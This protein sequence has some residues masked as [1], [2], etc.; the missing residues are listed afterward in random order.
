MGLVSGMVFKKHRAALTMRLSRLEHC[1]VYQKVLG[2][3]PGQG[4]YLRFW[5]QSSV[6]L[7]LMFL[8]HT[9]SLPPSLSQ[10]KKKQKTK[11]SIYISLGENF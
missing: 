3:I 6:G 4:T 1:P 7:T 11:K 9:L 10:K 8:S 5:V 2:L